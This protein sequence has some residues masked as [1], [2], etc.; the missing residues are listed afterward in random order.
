MAAL[1]NLASTLNVIIAQRLV[2]RICS[3]CIKSR[4]PKDAEEKAFTHQAE[5][6]KMEERTSLQ[7]FLFKGTGCDTCG[8][9]G[10]QGRIGIFELLKVTEKIRNM[11]LG[12]NSSE[13]IKKV[14]FSEGFE[15]MFEDGMQKVERGITTLEEVF[16]VVRE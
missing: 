4:P 6:L 12:R 9:S 1:G 15:T 3:R 16:R 2:R 8:G 14:G 5:L 10:Y 11:I 7:K 13:D